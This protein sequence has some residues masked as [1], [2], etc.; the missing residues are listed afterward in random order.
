MLKKISF[1][2]LNLILIFSVI[3]SN[4]SLAAST[5]TVPSNYSGAIVVKT[6]THYASG[7][8]VYGQTLTTYYMKPKKARAFASKIENSSTR[9]LVDFLGTSA[10]G[11]LSGK[12]LNKTWPGF[13]AG[14]LA[15]MNAQLKSNVAN[16]IRRQSE[17]GPVKIVY[18]QN[19]YLSGFGK[20]SSWNGKTISV[21][22][23][24]TTGSTKYGSA[25]Q[26]VKYRGM[27]Y[28]K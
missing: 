11:G 14:G 16:D 1:L 17:K 22:S 10:L 2:S 20:A 26:V 21:S 13:L 7:R 8:A 24:T 9:N 3:L 12:I 27:K 19:Q 5:K 4:V 28:L 23:Y 25:K 18:D 15:L 6:H